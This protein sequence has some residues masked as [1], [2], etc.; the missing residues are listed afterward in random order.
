MGMDINPAF[1]TRFNGGLKVTVIDKDRGLLYPW[2]M[3][4]GFNVG[5]S[6][7]QIG[8]GHV[9]NP[10]NPF[11]VPIGQLYPCLIGLYCANKLGT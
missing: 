8:Y 9:L 7:I 2:S 3:D 10:A 5:R 11:D 6:D 1:Q 4:G